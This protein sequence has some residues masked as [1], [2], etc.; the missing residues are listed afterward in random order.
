MSFLTDTQKTLFS[1]SFVFYDRGVILT[2]SGLNGLQ[3]ISLSLMGFLMLLTFLGANLQAALWQSSAWLVS[4]VLPA[5]VVDLTNSERSQNQ[6]APLVR[7]DV[8]DRAAQQKA[9]HMARQQYFAHY[10]PDGVSPWYWFEEVGYTYAHA[11]EN[12]A[13]HFTDSTEVVEAWMHSPAHRQNIV[14]QQYTE[15]GVGTAKGKYEGYDTVFVVQLFGTPAVPVVQPT[16]PAATSEAVTIETEVVAPTP[17]SGE[18]LPAVAAETSNQTESPRVVTTAT[19]AL[20]NET[21]QQPIETLATLSNQTIDFTAKD[22]VSIQLSPIATSSGL[23]VAQIVTP[24]E[25]K[26]AGFTLS[27]LATQPNT[28]LQFV[29]TT[30]A[31]VVV[32]LLSLSIVLET[33]GL[34]FTQVAYSIML[35][36]GMGTLWYLHTVLTS[37]AV[38]A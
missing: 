21:S 1:G 37:G 16:V 14:G 18:S 2:R 27:T 34:R 32:L 31:V 22:I 8:L 24:I 33:K 30:L 15:I 6:V 29:Y 35:L 4:T 12:L 28:A 11:G 9:E 10:S 36:C 25:A 19:E 38:V 7:S 17:V 20:T 5:V 3:K 13:I 23:A 26:H